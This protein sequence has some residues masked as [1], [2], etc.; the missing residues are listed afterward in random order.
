MSLVTFGV[1]FLCIYPSGIFRKDKCAE[2]H[3]LLL[4]KFCK[5]AE[6]FS[7]PERESSEVRHGIPAQGRDS[8]LWSSTGP[9][10]GT[11]LQ[12]NCIRN[13]NN[14]APWI[15]TVLWN[16]WIWDRAVEVAERVARLMSQNKVFGL[17]PF[18]TTYTLFDLG[19]VT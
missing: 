5:R 11:E 6:G 19:Q 7:S 15:R 4:L 2:S 14:N 9:P 10:F 16:R 12:H 8:P 1:I 13:H 3:F 18:F 17:S